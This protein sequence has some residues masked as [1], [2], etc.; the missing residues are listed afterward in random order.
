MRWTITAVICA[1]LLL[2]IGG[3]AFAHFRSGAVVVASGTGKPSRCSDTYRLVSLRPSEITT[4]H[5]VC[6]SAV[7]EVHGRARRHG[8]RGLHGQR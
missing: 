7:S 2:G 6:T 5:S 1:L 4:A 3:V 8:R